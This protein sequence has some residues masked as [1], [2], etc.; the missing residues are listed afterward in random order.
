MTD[1]MPEQ[2][3]DQQ[4][5]LGNETLI[6]VPSGQPVFLQDVVW[7]VPGPEGLAV[8]FRFIA[9]QIARDTGTVGYEEASEDIFHLCQTFALPRLSDFGPQPTQVIISFSD[10]PVPFGE[11]APEATQFFEAF[12][13]Q[14]GICMWEIY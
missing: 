5:E 9:P 7:N 12:T 4:I 1:P 8:R 3:S 2:Q 10:Q 11:T 13:H 14:D 6:P